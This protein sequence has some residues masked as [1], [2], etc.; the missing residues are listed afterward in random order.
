MDF[1]FF[2]ANIA[3]PSV[4]IPAIRKE[5][6]TYFEWEAFFEYDPIRH[7]VNMPVHRPDKF[8]M[9]PNGAVGTDGNPVL[10]RSVVLVNRIAAPYQK[11][12]VSRASAFLTGGGYSIQCKPVIDAETKA[13]E[14]IKTTLK[15]NKID[16]KNSELAKRVLSE[17]EAAEIWYSKVNADKTVSMKCNIY[18]PSDG[19]SLMP[20]F[21]NNR[22]LIA[23]SLEYDNVSDRKRYHDIY[24]AD[25][26]IRTVNTG[27][28]WQL[29][30]GTPEQPNPLPLKYGKIPV[31]YYSIDRSVWQDVQ[32]IINRLELLISNF[33][34][35]NDYNGSPILA[36]IGEI[37]GF[38]AKGE[39][40]K[41]MELTEGADLK[42]VTWDQAPESIKLEMDTLSDLIFN[43]TQ[44]PN[45]SFKEMKG[46]GDISGVAFDRIM[47]DAH[48]KA[49]DAQD[50]W[51][52][53]GI[54]RRLNFL[55]AACI[56]TG[57]GMDAA[58]DLEI[59]PQFNLFK[60]DSVGESIDIAMKGNGNK[61]VMTQKES[62]ALAGVSDDV[63]AT[64]EQLQLEVPS[65]PI[66][67][68]L[69]K[70]N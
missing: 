45:I 53:Q 47:I 27:G 55:L 30:P 11:I 12:I 13:F 35:I 16:F 46:L 1:S 24:T 56:A 61:P 4:L 6:K 58:K 34:D 54:Q 41:V 33:G 36:A 67:L 63:E 26:L 49:K 19:Y 7:K 70:Q 25:K 38:M 8:V 44:T 60:I 40:G 14:A 23:F 28:G 17:T 5:W 68:N 29:I 62:I 10:E 37:K 57:T 32:Q 52:G 69:D 9:K 43:M 20:V 59:T 3:N 42:Y 50:G 15:K 22:D 66:N 51:Y 2:T 64:Y 48:L 65:V 21:D 18:S 31:I 39:T